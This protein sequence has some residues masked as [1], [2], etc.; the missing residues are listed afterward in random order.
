M[1]KAGRFAV[2]VGIQIVALSVFWVACVATFQADEMIV[3]IAA[4]ALSV[5]FCVYVIHT[6]PL[7]FKPTLRDLVQVWRL[8]WYVVTDLVRVMWILVRDCA[9]HPAP[10]HFFSA[11]WYAVANTGRDTARRALAVAYTTVSPNCI[12]IGIDCGRRQILVH[13][14]EPSGISRM[15]RN[16]GGENPGGRDVE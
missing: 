12:V 1:T 4:V 2:Q 16:L 9:G 3:G 14:L 13:Q 6:L 15:T 8:P 10:S 7:E 11:P 5:A